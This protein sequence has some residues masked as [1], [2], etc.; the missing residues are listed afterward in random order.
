L[1]FG[2]SRFDALGISVSA[3]EEVASVGSFEDARA[4]FNE[5]IRCFNDAMKCYTQESWFTEH[6]EILI[7][8]SNLY[9]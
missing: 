7:D 9:R 6:F 4:V 1:F 2:A 8:V 5:G 3:A